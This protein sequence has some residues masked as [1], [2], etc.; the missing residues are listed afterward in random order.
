MKETVNKRMVDRRWNELKEKRMKE[1]GVEPNEWVQSR[2]LN[3]WK[4]KSMRKLNKL[5]K[6]TKY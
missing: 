2:R 4:R 5:K 1:L 6:W 3:E